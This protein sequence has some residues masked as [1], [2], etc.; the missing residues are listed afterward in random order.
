MPDKS[1]P[2]KAFNVTLW[3]AQV[4]IALCLLMGAV[5]K[6]MPI[7][8]ISLMMPWTGQLPSLVVRLLGTIDLLGALGLVLPAL[9]RIKPHL[10]VW[11]ALGTIALMFSAV[12][13]HIS[14]GEGSVIGFNLFLIVLSAFVAWGRAKKIPIASK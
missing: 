11:A 1:T 6:F 14:R 5:M 12:I 8:K 9:L 13:F 4:F 2:S 7:E 3:I 10:V